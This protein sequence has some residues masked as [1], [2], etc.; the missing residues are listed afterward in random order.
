MSTKFT[1]LDFEKSIYQIEDKIDEL[2]TLSSETGIDLQDQIQTLT[3]QA[4]EYKE[5]L[6]SN[7]APAQKVQIARHS[8]RPTFLDY[9][10]MMSTDWVELHGDRAG[11]D[12]RAIIGG[13]AQI[14][15]RPVMIIGTQKGKTTKENIE[16]NF[17]MPH[18]EGYRKALRLFYHADKFNL[19]IITM[20]DTPGAYPGI[21]A[22]QTGQGT[23]IAVNLREMAKINVPI[24][25]VVTGEGCSGGALGLAVANKVYM[26][27]HA[28]YTVISPEGCASILWRSAE[29]ASIAAEALRITASDLLKLNIIDGIIKEPL[30][31]AHYDPEFTAKSLADTV[32]KTIDELSQKSGNEL[33]KLR[34]EKFRKLGIFLE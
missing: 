32:I 28:Y 5:Q 10:S 1:P 23:A 3:K 15:D 31:G 16:Y 33:K 6:Y 11:T 26:L 29:Q 22:E 21:K 27:E 18:P 9:I 12:D 13:I 14:Q 7:L 4:E 34:H 17:G 24:I 2:K 20:I 19:P 30:G 25:A 8:K